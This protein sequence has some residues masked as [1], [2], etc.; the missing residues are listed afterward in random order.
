MFL[1]VIALVV[2][3]IVVFVLSICHGVDSNAGVAAFF[4]FI[5][6]FFTLLVVSSMVRPSLEYEAGRYVESTVTKTKF[7]T[8]VY[9]GEV[10]TFE[11]DV[12]TSRKLSSFNE[13]TLF[14]NEK[15]SLSGIRDVVLEVYSLD[16]EWTAELV[17]FR[18]TVGPFSVAPV[19][20][21]VVLLTKR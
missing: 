11:D 15:V 10:F 1:A 12:L 20:R 3:S 19:D 9:R 13:V 6:S 8:I 5:L 16:G 7:T 18:G 2:V 4:V 14:S 21:R 17:T